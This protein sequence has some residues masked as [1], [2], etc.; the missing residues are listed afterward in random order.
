MT[1]LEIF[2]LTLQTDFLP[3]NNW[4]LKWAREPN[5]KF[6]LHAHNISIFLRNVLLCIVF[7][8]PHGSIMRFY[9]NLV[10]NAQHIHVFY[11]EASNAGFVLFEIIWKQIILSATHKKTKLRGLSPRANYTD[12]A[13]A[14]FRRSYWQF[15]RI[16]GATWSAWQ[17]PTAVISFF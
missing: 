8:S 12:R 7:Q 14:A 3:E 17:I 13:I 16:G 1:Y 10:L 15:F 11:R 4:G 6:Q 5:L 2:L 9:S